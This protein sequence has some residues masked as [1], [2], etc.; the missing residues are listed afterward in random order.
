LANT[1]RILRI[2]IRKEMNT[3]VRIEL[4]KETSCNYS[5]MWSFIKD[6][7]ELGKKYSLSIEVIGNEP[8]LTD[9]ANH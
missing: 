8:M 3:N 2:R 6:I 4:D 1:K 5:K 7:H 9:H